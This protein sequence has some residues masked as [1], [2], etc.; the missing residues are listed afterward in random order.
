VSDSTQRSVVSNDPARSRKTI[1]HVLAYC[2][3]SSI[4]VASLVCM[5][6]VSM[7]A[8][9]HGRRTQRDREGR[10]KGGQ[11]IEEAV[12]EKIQN[13]ERET[14]LTCSVTAQ[15]ASNMCYCQMKKRKMFRSGW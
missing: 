2:D 3:P 4:N 10:K 8:W 12:H 7:G 5:V 1:L 9:V 6:H 13:L 15:N 11:K 14:F